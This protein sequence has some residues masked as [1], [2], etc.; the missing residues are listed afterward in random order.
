MCADGWFIEGCLGKGIRG[1]Q[2]ENVGEQ[3]RVGDA[4]L[5]NER[6]ALLRREFERETECGFYLLISFWRHEQMRDRLVRPA[7]Q[8]PTM[9]GNLSAVPRSITS[10]RMERKSH[11][12]KNFYGFLG[13]GAVS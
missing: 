11:H 4:E 12:C 8:P 1:E 13:R 7:S 6:F 3:G 10:A 5:A 2:S 9:P